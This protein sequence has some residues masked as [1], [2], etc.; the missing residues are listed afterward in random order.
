[1]VTTGDKPHEWPSFGAAG[2]ARQSG[3]KRVTVGNGYLVIGD[4]GEA[5]VASSALTGKP[6]GS[7]G[8]A[9]GL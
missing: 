7:D 9:W 2:F 1:V 5:W 3:D 8:G 4:S 6:A